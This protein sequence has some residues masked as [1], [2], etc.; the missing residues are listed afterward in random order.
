MAAVVSAMF[1][2]FIKS[3]DPDGL[4]PME[5]GAGSGRDDKDFQLGPGAI[6][7][8][9]PYESVEIADPNARTQPLISLCWP[10]CGKLG[11]ALE[12]PFELLVKHFTA[13][14]SAAQAALLEAWKFFRSRRE[15]LACMFCQPFMRL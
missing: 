5:D 14:Y 13:S 7:D 9:Y 3:E 6:L 12:I 2:V 15:W 8:L 1:S 4:A 11:V 10:S